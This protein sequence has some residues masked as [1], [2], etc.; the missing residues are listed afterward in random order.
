MKNIKN[1]V[2]PLLLI[3]SVI[4]NTQLPVWAL[5]ARLKEVSHIEGVRE[6]QVV[7]YGLVVGLSK[8]GDKSRSTQIMGQNMLLNFGSIV[9]SANDIRLNNTAAVI[10]TANVPAF[11]KAGDR[12]D[13]VVSSIADAKSLEGGVLVQTQLLAPNGEVVALAQG[14]VS[15]GGSSASASGSSVRTSITTSGRVPNGAIIE[16]P[17]QT[18]IGD[19]NSIT[20]VLDKTDFDLATKVA[21]AITAYGYAALA[22]DGASVRVDLPQEAQFNRV[23]FI[24]KIQNLIVDTSNDSVKVVVNERTGTI[25]I[26]NRVKLLPAA[27]AHGGIT[28][29]IKANNS[30]S[31]PNAPT[32]INGNGG[33]STVNSGGQ[34]TGVTNSQISIDEKQGSLIELSPSAS[35]QDLVAALNAIGATPNDLISILQALKEAGSLQAELEII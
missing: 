21:D 22:M 18:E 15:V 6:N 20:L 33:G 31:Q 7:G 19:S 34:T 14:P 30:V 28:V 4:V 1:V 8:S 11:A 5:K 29:T 35:L 32:V 13:V 12:I 2:L 27:V 25:V 9:Q 16:R 3:A 24:S 17:I 26:G 10:V 23:P